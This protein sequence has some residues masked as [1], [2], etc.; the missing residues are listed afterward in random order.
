MIELQKLNSGGFARIY[1]DNVNSDYILKINK[2]TVDKQEI[3]DT[4]R[5]EIYIYEY[6]KKHQLDKL[7]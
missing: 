6:L 7:T 5:N 1:L 3:I 2:K 4:L